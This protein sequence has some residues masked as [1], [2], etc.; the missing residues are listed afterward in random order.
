MPY[1]QKP[2]C[3]LLGYQNAAERSSTGSQDHLKHHVVGPLLYTH[4]LPAISCLR[5]SCLTGIL[6]TKFTR[7]Y[8]STLAKLSTDLNISAVGAEQQNTDGGLRHEAVGLQDQGDQ[9]AISIFD[10]DSEWG[11]LASA[12]EQDAAVLL[13]KLKGLQIAPAGN[14]L[15]SSWLLGSDYLSA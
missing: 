10:E 6:D 14:I 13:Q 9:I 1:A 12:L 7:L 2:Q 15:A 8:Q 11:A 4:F 3:I 5:P